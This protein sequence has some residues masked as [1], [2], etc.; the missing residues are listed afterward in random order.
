[1]GDFLEFFGKKSM[2]G[3]Q[4]WLFVKKEDLFNIKDCIFTNLISN[5][6][7]QQ[8]LR[9]KHSLFCKPALI[10]PTKL[11][12]RKPPFKR[13]PYLRDKIG[14]TDFSLKSR[15]H[16]ICL[17]F[18]VAERKKIKLLLKTP[19]T[20][21]ENAFAHHIVKEWYVNSSSC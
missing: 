6:F 8:H 3:L 21:N 2:Q 4:T 1:M 14:L 9:H 18:F 16:C 5:Y 10:L 11:A 7:T 13:N 20:E 17:I 12:I 15:F 19:L